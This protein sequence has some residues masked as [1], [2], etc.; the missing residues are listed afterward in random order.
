MNKSLFLFSLILI[1]SLC[2]STDNQSLEPTIKDSLPSNIPFIKKTLWGEKGILR[3]TFIN[4][5]SRIKE[6]EMR[7]NML[8]LHQKVALFTL[9]TMLYQYNLGNRMI[10]NPEEYGQLKDTHMKLGY[11]TFTTYI[12]AAGLSILS[13]PA[14]KYTNKRFT[15]NKIHQYLAFIHFTGMMLQPWLGYHTSVAGIECQNGIQGR[16]YDRRQ[17][18]DFH[19]TVGGITVSTYFL[20]F[21]MT[22]LR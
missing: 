20:S 16:C 14:M 8:Q 22:L 5:Q 13:P 12:T 6:I 19:E 15:S 1:T 3:N 17:L 9:G 21:L 7:H 10:E 4:P 18:Q 11:F 2:S